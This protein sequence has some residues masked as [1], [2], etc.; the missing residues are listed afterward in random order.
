MA[1]QTW[2]VGQKA[3]TGE[4][5]LYRDSDFYDERT[6]YLADGTTPDN[7]PPGTTLTYDFSSDG[8]TWTTGW[9]ATIDGA[10]AVWNVDKAQVNA[11]KS[12]ERVRLFYV[13]G[14]DEQTLWAGKVA[15]Y[16]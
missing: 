8:Y 4:M 7:W 16:R 9:A 5:R 2:D 12:G 11:R 1:A 13:N 15:I 6:L 3:A 14:S 10:D